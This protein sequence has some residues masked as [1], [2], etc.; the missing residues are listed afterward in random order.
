MLHKT[1]AVRTVRYGSCWLKAH[2]YVRLMHFVW[3]LKLQQMLSNISDD[4]K[5]VPLPL[6][7]TNAVVG[8]SSFSV[9]LKHH[10]LRLPLVQFSAYRDFISS[11]FQIIISSQLYLYYNILYLVI[12]YNL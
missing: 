11:Y 10:Q 9:V 7:F 4:H 5:S 1:Q 8:N 12:F 3:T 6:C 2:R